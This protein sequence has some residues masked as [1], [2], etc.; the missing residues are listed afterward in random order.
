ML[1]Y[2]VIMPRE[3]RKIQLLNELY[4]MGPLSNQDLS[5]A[6]DLSPASITH[7]LQPLI[8]DQILR[9]IAPKH[10]PI[11]NLNSGAALTHRRK[12]TVFPNPLYG[13]ALVAELHNSW[14]ILRKIDFSLS[15]DESVFHSIYLDESANAEAT[16]LEHIQ[17]IKH[18]SKE[19]L[20]AC[21]L[22]SHPVLDGKQSG[23]LL[24]DAHSLNRI[25]HSLNIPVIRTRLPHAIAIGEQSRNSASQLLHYIVIH[26]HD[27]VNLGIVVDG[28]PYLGANNKA[29]ECG[30]LLLY[31]FGSLN[32]QVGSSG[33]LIQLEAHGMTNHDFNAWKTLCD[34]VLQASS[35]STRSDDLNDAGLQ[36]VV[37]H[38]CYHIALLISNIA[39]VAAP[40]QFYVSGPISEL[41][42]IA[43]DSI[44][45]S[46]AKL[47]SACLQ[48]TNNISL[49]ADWKGRMTEGCAKEAFSTLFL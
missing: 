13:Y 21:G 1:Q 45:R 23:F 27:T 44:M 15:I 2:L 17:R 8:Q 24:L 49:I 41:G 16:L 11:A 42:D 29:G 31:H 25:S 40:E 39:Y 6:M 33:L 4:R 10:Y 14:A 20:V 3:N 7:L 26:V 18:E 12:T 22:C 37:D 28:K 47:N 32:D 9:E 5:L 46:L 19:T 48:D 35:G 30:E 43:L 34:H 36:A 38:I